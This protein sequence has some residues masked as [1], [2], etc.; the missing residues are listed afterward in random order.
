LADSVNATYV[1]QYQNSGFGFLNASS[2][3]LNNPLRNG[4]SPSLPTLA[5]NPAVLL[6][7][8]EGRT[9]QSSAYRD[10]LILGT[11]R[12]NLTVNGGNV[13]MLYQLANIGAS[14]STD[15]RGQFVTY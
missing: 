11:Y 4:V 14:A 6:I 2:A 3:P 5:Q 10:G 8:D 1:G 15:F 7:R 12:R 13:L 9:V